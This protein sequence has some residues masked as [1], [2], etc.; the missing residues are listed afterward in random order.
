MSTLLKFSLQLIESSCQLRNL[1]VNLEVANLATDLQK[2][3]DIRCVP[4]YSL[5]THIVIHALLHECTLSKIL[6]VI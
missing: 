2:L 4:L 6:R 3:H 5:Y 1:N